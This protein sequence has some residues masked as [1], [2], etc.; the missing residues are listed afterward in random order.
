MNIY[1]LI[2]NAGKNT[3]S[4]EFL[5]N[6]PSIFTLIGKGTTFGEVKLVLNANYFFT[7]QQ[8]SKFYRIEIVMQVVTLVTCPL[9]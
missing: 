7:L 6:N 4:S 8:K 2:L 1:M 3:F 5:Q 9:N